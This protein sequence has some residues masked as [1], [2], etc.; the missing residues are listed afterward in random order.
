MTLMPETNTNQTKANCSEY[1]LIV[2]GSGPAG[3][4]AAIQASKL[5]K[6]VCIIEKMPD[7]I[8]GAWIQT[9]TLPSKTIRESLEAIHNIRH[10]A[11]AQ[12][13]SRVIEDLSATKLY[14]R[15]H[16]VSAEEESLVRRYLK[17]NRIEVVG[18]FASFEGPHSVRITPTA[19]VGYNLTAKVFVIAT[20]SRPRRPAEIPFDGWRVVDSDEILRLESVP[21]HMLIY[22][23]GVIGCEYACIFSALGVETLLADS[24]DRLMQQLDFEVVKELEKSMTEMGVKFRLGQEIK[25]ITPKGPKVSVQMTSETI[26]TDVLFF[27]AGRLSNSDKMGLE[28]LKDESSAHLRRRRRR[29]LP[30]TCCDLDATR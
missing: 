6:S 5:G 1:D 20:G 27:A 2:I 28:T 16:K 11:G 21:K 9:G 30:C 15:A 10:H 24:R 29:R 13:V 18:G 22:G 14:R 3:V 8:G 7:H 25:T 23:A 12:W 4:Q 19:G 26:E 17:K